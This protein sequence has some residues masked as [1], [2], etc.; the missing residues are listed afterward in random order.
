MGRKRKDADNID[1]NLDESYKEISKKYQYLPI[2]K[3]IEDNTPFDKKQSWLGLST[4][5]VDKVMQFLTDEEVA[6]YLKIQ[7]KICLDGYFVVDVK[8]NQKEIDLLDEINSKFFKISLFKWKR[9]KIKILQLVLRGQKIFQIFLN[10]SF[11][12]LNVC[13]TSSANRKIL[14]EDDTQSLIE[15]DKNEVFSNIDNN[16]SNAKLENNSN[17]KNNSNSKNELESMPISTNK[18]KISN[19]NT[20]N[21]S[22]NSKNNNSNLENN[23]SNL[24]NNNSNLENNGK[25]I[26]ESNI[27][28][29]NE[30]ILSNNEFLSN[31]RNFG[32]NLQNGGENIPVKKP[33]CKMTKQEQE[34]E[35]FLSCFEEWAKENELRNKEPVFKSMF[36]IDPQE[37]IEYRKQQE[38]NKRKIGIIKE[39]IQ[40]STLAELG[41][42]FEE[43]LERQKSDEEHE[44]QRQK[45]IR[46]EKLKLAYENCRKRR[47]EREAKENAH[48]NFENR[49]DCPENIQEY[50]FTNKYTNEFKYDFRQLDIETLSKFDLSKEYSYYYYLWRKRILFS[51]TK[52]MDLPFDRFLP[53]LRIT[54]DEQKIRRYQIRANNY[55]Q[56][57]FYQLDKQNYQKILNNNVIPL[58]Q[59]LMENGETIAV[60]FQTEVN[61]FLNRQECQYFTLDDNNFIYLPFD[62]SNL[63]L[64]N[65][66]QMVNY[67]DICF[68]S[69]KEE[70]N[71]EINKIQEYNTNLLDE[72]DYKVKINDFKYTPFMKTEQLK[73]LFNLP[74]K[75]SIEEILKTDEYSQEYSV[76]EYEKLVKN[77]YQ[78]DIHLRIIMFNLMLLNIKLGYSYNRV[79]NLTI[80][81]KKLIELVKS[82]SISI[83]E[84]LCCAKI[85]LF[86]TSKELSNK[87]ILSQVQNNSQVILLAMLSNFANNVNNNNLIY[88]RDGYNKAHTELRQVVLDNDEIIKKIKGYNFDIL[89]DNY[90]RDNT[91]FTQ[92]KSKIMNYIQDYQI[93]PNIAKMEINDIALIEDFIQVGFNDKAFLNKIKYMEKTKKI[94]K[95]ETLVNIKYLLKC[96]KNEIKVIQE[97]DPIFKLQVQ[98]RLELTKL[99]KN[100]KS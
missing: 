46:E 58:K 74:Y 43:A 75:L 72:N 27:S 48:L 59:N 84:V 28:F 71:N 80:L 57:I 8:N 47:L 49:I 51:S 4:T 68:I 77:D 93:V 52:I 65:N 10:E 9:L 35:D 39:P 55:Y 30:N 92:I 69:N 94:N 70:F 12:S 83:F 91:K 67:S 50:L 20:I 54:E 61:K 17:I 6:I 16:K 11:G 1:M 98:T 76:S 3:I 60:N 18:E 42:T 82:G 79:I 99:L 33:Y 45:E 26:I 86:A 34:R 19:K 95:N 89:S 29:G 41:L 2:K 13:L 62:F 5:E 7:I 97:I 66:L 44:K 40:G 25:A 23:N 56:G 88:D 81:N 87:E 53:N 64:N 90:P 22:L 24:E 31:E 36:D 73:L 15:T 63:K 32:N 37:E 85:I 21:N 100:I 96:F 38:A 78:L 14:F